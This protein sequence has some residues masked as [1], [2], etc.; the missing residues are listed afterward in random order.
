[1]ALIF[2]WNEEHQQTL[3]YV[4]VAVWLMLILH[5]AAAAGPLRVPLLLLMVVGVTV[6][7]LAEKKEAIAREEGTGGLKKTYKAS[8]SRKKTCLRGF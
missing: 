6:G 3:R 2:L 7:F 5:V 4:S 8:L 1:M